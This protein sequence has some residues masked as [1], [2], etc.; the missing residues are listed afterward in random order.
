MKPARLLAAA[1]AAFAVFICLA[2]VAPA[3]PAAES[4]ATAAEAPAAPEAAEAPRRSG[5]P[6]NRGAIGATVRVIDQPGDVTV[7]GGDVTV[8]GVVGGSVWVAGGDVNAPGHVGG[9]LRILGGDV[10]FSGTAAREFSAAGGSV[11]VSG[12]IGR[13]LQ[14]AG[15]EI[16]LAPGA[17]VG[18]DARIAGGQLIVG[19]RIGG[20]LDA[21]GERITL[22]GII[23]GDARVRARRIQIGPNARILGR[24]D[25]QARY[26]LDID[27]AAQTP[28]GLSGRATESLDFQ[29]WREWTPAQANP[30]SAWL[31]AAAWSLTW[32][33]SAFLAGVVL[34]A[35]A[36]RLFERAWE[37]AHGRWLAALAWG[38]LMLIAPILIAIALIATL[39]GLPIGVLTLMAYPFF[40]ASGHALGAATLGSLVIQREGLGRRIA[41]LAIGI[42]FIAILGL[43]PVVGGV[44]GSLVLLMGLGLF[45]LR[46]R[47][48]HHPPAPAPAPS[49]EATPPPT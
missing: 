23:Q 3:Q 14:A 20:D 31:A 33:L 22:D 44:A 18:A 45:A 30:L 17:E 1:F 46:E 48:H 5:Y 8:D 29:K 6:P 27:P 25:W 34:A 28:G 10:D 49:A 43:I 38:A 21:A 40:L 39:V 13:A 32:A 47:H 11:L 35:A 15:G 42:A 41:A 24:L 9:D 12:R 26:P 16:E 4:A 37:V 19:G 7:F 36:P 2:P